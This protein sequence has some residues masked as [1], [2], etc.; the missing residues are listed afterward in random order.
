MHG[1]IVVQLVSGSRYVTQARQL[2]VEPSH[3]F[4]SRY[5]CYPAEH[6]SLS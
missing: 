2:V 3:P 1:T 5:G 4:Q 6:D